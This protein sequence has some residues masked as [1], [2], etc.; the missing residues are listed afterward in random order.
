M[1]RKLIVYKLQRA[2]G[3][4]EPVRVTVDST[5][6]RL[7]TNLTGS[8][9]YSGKS[10]PEG[11]MGGN[12]GKTLVPEGDESFFIIRTGATMFCRAN[13]VAPWDICPAPV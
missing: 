5:W 8:A 2:G 6:E 13:W 7:M 3:W 12:A 4:C 1:S 9:R 10:W 11:N